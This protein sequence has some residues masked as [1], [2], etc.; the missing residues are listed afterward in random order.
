MLSQAADVLMVVRNAN[1]HPKIFCFLFFSFFLFQSKPLLLTE[2]RLSTWL[3]GTQISFDKQKSVETTTE[4][5]R[6]G[7]YRTVITVVFSTLHRR[8][9]TIVKFTH[10]STGPDRLPD[11]VPTYSRT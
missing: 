9:Q 11:H 2:K 6:T 1:V 10:N 3:P 4:K 7:D 8:T 5:M